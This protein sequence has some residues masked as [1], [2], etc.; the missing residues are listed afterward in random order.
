MFGCLF[1]CCFTVF[2]VWVFK[3]LGLGLY[4]RLDLFVLGFLMVG[5]WT[6]LRLLCFGYLVVSLVV[7]CWCCVLCVEGLLVSLFTGFGYGWA[8]YACGLVRLG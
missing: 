5:V 3:L 6:L 2:V 8:Y 1:F 4:L 7:V